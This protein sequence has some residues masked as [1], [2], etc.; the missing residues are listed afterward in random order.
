MTNLE[1]DSIG[2]TQKACA[3]CGM[4]VSIDEAVAFSNVLDRDG[5][6]RSGK[7]EIKEALTCLECYVDSKMAASVRERMKLAMEVSSK[8]GITPMR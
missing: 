2:V 1:T 6:T 3:V 8:K 4:M 7:F 5:M